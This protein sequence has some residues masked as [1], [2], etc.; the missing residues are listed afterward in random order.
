MKF[1][2]MIRSARESLGLSQADVADIVGVKASAVTQWETGVSL[3]FAER[4]GAIADCLHLKEAEVLGTIYAER[5]QRRADKAAKPDS[6]AGKPVN[7]APP[8]PLPEVLAHELARPLLELRA[9]GGRVLLTEAGTI[10]IELSDAT[11]TFA[12]LYMEKDQ[13]RALGRVLQNV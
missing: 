2:D 1:A 10:Q 5:K 12:N 11:G 3:P 13:A 4:S 7:K 8:T 6:P 9:S